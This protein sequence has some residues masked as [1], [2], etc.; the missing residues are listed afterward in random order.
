MYQSP[1]NAHGFNPQ[2]IY[3][4]PISNLRQVNDLNWNHDNRTQRIYDNIP[5]E[6][7]S[8][9]NQQ[10]APGYGNFGQQNYS[11]LNDPNKIVM[12]NHANGFSSL[13]PISNNPHP[14]MRR[15]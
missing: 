10:I 3:R 6:Q 8:V 9:G 2:S 5:Y 4:Q 1:V 11:S 7:Y 12:N 15:M 14:S 13:P